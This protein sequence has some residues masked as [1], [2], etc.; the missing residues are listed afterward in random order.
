[1]TIA[2]AM[3]SL[4]VVGTTANL[5]TIVYAEKA[6]DPNCFGE[7]YILANDTVLRDALL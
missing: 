5:S 2:I 7:E 6:D 4:A 3:L 1:M